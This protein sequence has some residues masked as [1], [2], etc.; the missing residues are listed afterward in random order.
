MARFSASKREPIAEEHTAAP[1][2]EP[3]VG[4]NTEEPPDAGR[5]DSSWELLKGLEV[6][7]LDDLP[8]EWPSA[9]VASH[10]HR[11]G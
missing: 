1:P 4:A 6:A 9:T 5:F 8:P 3:I 11:G 2:T 10:P 7:E